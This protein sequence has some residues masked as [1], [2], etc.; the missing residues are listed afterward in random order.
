M[1]GIGIKIICG[2][3]KKHV[4]ELSAGVN[5]KKVADYNIIC[6]DCAIKLRKENN[7]LK[8]LKYWKNELLN[9]LYTDYVELL[10][11]I[12]D[13]ADMKKSWDKNNS[14]S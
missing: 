12:Q 7:N 6:P 2:W 11:A 14:R 4:A 10:Q 1:G 5:I 13:H 3:C 9:M 8:D